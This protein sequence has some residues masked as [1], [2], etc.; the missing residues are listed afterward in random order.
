MRDQLVGLAFLALI[1]WS[2]CRKGKPRRRAF[3]AAHSHGNATKADVWRHEKGHS[4]LLRKYKVGVAAQR[5]YQSSAGGWSGWTEPASWTRFDRLPPERR[6]AVYAAGGIAMGSHSHD[7][8][9]NGDIREVLRQ[10]PARDR[11]RVEAAG[12]A[13]ARKDL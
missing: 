13:L 6:I 3:G 2:L 7:G 11:N 1:V 12:R 4:R 9:D 8:Q 5:V 10:V